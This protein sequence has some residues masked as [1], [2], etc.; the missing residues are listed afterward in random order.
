MQVITGDDEDYG[1][2]AEGNP[3]LGSVS[4]STIVGHHYRA[5]GSYDWGHGALFVGRLEA[6]KMR[7]QQ[8]LQTSPEL[9]E[10]QSREMK[11]R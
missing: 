3:L 8:L 6:R 10:K 7:T 1:R 9:L 2:G 4:A 11:T 5:D